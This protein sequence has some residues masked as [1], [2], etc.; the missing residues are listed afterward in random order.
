MRRRLTVRTLAVSALII[1]VVGAVLGGLALGIDRQHD[2]GERARHSQSVI[3]T[4]NLTQQ[5]L[6]AVQT[7]LRGFLIGANPN[8]LT[9]YRGVRESFPAAAL[10]LQGLVADNPGQSRLA[11]EIRRQALSY[12]DSYADPLI[13]RTREAGVGAGRRFAAAHDGGARADELEALISRFGS[14]EQ[15]L[16]QQRARTADS[17]SSRAL[18]TA[19]LGFALCVLVLV[20]A[21][22]YVARRIVMPV[23]RLAEAASRVQRGELDVTVPE[24]RG[25]EIGRLGAAFNAMARSLEQSRGELESQNTELEMQA[26]ELEERQ[27]E[28]SEANDETRAQRDELEVSASHLAAEKARAERYGEFANRLAMSRNAA[29]LTEITLSTLAAAAGADVGVLYTENWRDDA[30]WTRTAVLAL[31][32]APL[33]E[34]APTGGEGAGAR[35]VTSRSVV[36]VEGAAAG[37]RVRTG[38][39]GEAVVRWEVHVPLRSGERAVGVASLGGVTEAPFDPAEASTLE[40]LAAQAAVAL[41]EAGA[42]AQR[43]WLSQVNSAVLDCVREGIALVGLDHELIFANAAME[44]L[45][46]RLSMPIPA[47]IGASREDSSEDDPETYF[48]QWEAMLADTD[49]PTADELEISGLVLERYTAPVDDDEGARIGRLVVLRDVSR[50]RE[51]D[52]LK[53]DLMA[54]VSHE[55]RTPLA[56]VLGYA[57]LLRTRQLEPAARDEILGTVHREA[58][59]LSALIDD[60]LDVQAIEQDRLTLAREPFSVTEL[61]QEQVR[62][63]A[64]QSAQHRV[65]LSPCESSAMAI[66]DRAR[67]S[68]VVANLLSNAIKYS[69]DGGDVNVS[70]SCTAGVVLVA[71][72]DAGLGIP[73]D[74]QPHVF[75][76]F[77]RVERGAAQRVGGTGLGLALAHEIVLAHGGRMGFESTEGAGSRFWFTLPTE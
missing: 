52:Q 33:A 13:E 47:A 44:Q 24:R 15:K 63:F 41:T 34:F 3:A 57:E 64:G 32:P 42:L 16:S 8:L 61:L 36:V 60:F 68:Q 43:N 67:I 66:G 22:A 26:I 72:T 55:L 9:D 56:S 48:A 76:K 30:R 18:L 59:R 69:P 71:V 21:T 19:G 39:G 50:E 14:V 23:G 29:D 58:K 40:R 12:V 37:L 11:L 31:D 75:E 1:V 28:L 51:V 17:A 27:V 73:A 49:E 10:E 25:D 65:Q 7:T 74:D 2:A 46:G 6:L 45:A 70:A 38:L 77:F 5:R 35:A 62:T 53:S 20:L 4:A 54:A